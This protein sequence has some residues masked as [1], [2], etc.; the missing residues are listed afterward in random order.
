MRDPLY[1]SFF[2]EGA[3]KVLN[4]NIKSNIVEQFFEA[5]K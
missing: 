5:I 1:I 4:S 2:L 3:L